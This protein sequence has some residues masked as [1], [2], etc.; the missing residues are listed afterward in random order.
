MNNSDRWCHLGNTMSTTDISLSR[1]S[2][3]PGTSIRPPS[4]SANIHHMVF[5]L[6]SKRPRSNRQHAQHDGPVS[7]L[8]ADPDL[9]FVKTKFSK[10]VDKSGP[11]DRYS[12]RLANRFGV[13]VND[14]HVITIGLKVA[15]VVT[16]RESHFWGGPLNRLFYDTWWQLPRR[17]REIWTT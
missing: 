14:K 8:T 17:R 12:K 9:R 15:P 11:R 10:I 16:A 6:H 2:S 13:G 7:T 3:R 5:S 1:I 4:R